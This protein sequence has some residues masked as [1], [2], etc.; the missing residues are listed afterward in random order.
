[1]NSANPERSLGLTQRNSLVDAGETALS[2]SLRHCFSGIFSQYRHLKSGALALCVASVFSSAQADPFDWLYFPMYSRDTAHAVHLSALKLRPDGL[3]DSATRYPRVPEEQWTQAESEA[4]WNDYQQRLI[5]CETGFSIVHREHLLSQEGNIIA[6]RDNTAANLAKW[7][8]G[9]ANEMRQPSWPIANE[10]FLACAAAGD[11]QFLAQR[12]QQSKKKVEVFS[13]T[14]RIKALKAETQDIFWPKTNF[15]PDID[16]LLKHPPADPY[17]L[18]DKLQRQYRAW[19]SG[20]AP[21]LA[22]QGKSGRESAVAGL[23]EENQ[24]WL[25]AQQIQV[26]NVASRPDGAVRYTNLQPG[27]ADL[28]ADYREVPSKLRNAEA[29]ELDMYLDCQSGRQVPSRLVWL[30]GERKP[31]LGIPIGVKPI[32]QAL[33]QQ[34]A[35]NNDAVPSNILQA[36]SN[37]AICQAV[38][39]QCQG[40]A[41]AELSPFKFSTQDEEAIK[42]ADSPAAALL[43][44]REAYRN[45]RRNFIPNCAV[46][47]PF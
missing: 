20:F 37:S 12:R 16:G 9:L 38:A 17:A 19:L 2:N 26:A 22:N 43:V 30:D 27:Y 34:A 15:R 24:R 14:P 18:F 36:P 21:E 8:V 42:Q 25:A 1:M 35:Y 5:D 6:S 10:I 29:A 32:L 13:Y 41:P 23:S 28:P 11:A 40:K 7:K 45:Y 4:G 31:L 39:A 46:G 3:L 33:K 47:K 44:V